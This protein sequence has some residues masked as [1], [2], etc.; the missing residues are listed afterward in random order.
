M[1]SWHSCASSGRLSHSVWFRFGARI[2]IGMMGDFAA[3]RRERVALIECLADLD[4]KAT[5]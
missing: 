3:L 4:Q 1:V 2:L 5:T